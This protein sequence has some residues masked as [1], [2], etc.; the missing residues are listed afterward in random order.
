MSSRMFVSAMVAAALLPV[1]A[2][3]EDKGLFIGL[4]GAGGMATGSS[5]AT[6]G[7]APF[8]GASVVDS[9]DFG[10]TIG[11]GGHVG[12]RFNPALSVFVSYQHVRGDISWDADFP[13]IGVT[14]SF[15][16]DA[17]SNVVMGNIAYDRPVSEATSLTVAAGVGISFNA[18]SAVV[19]TDQGT[20]LFLADLAE[21]TRISPAAQIALGVRHRVASNVQLGLNLSVGYS[22]GF[23]TGDTRTGNL[24]VTPINPYKIDD[25]WRASLGASMRFEF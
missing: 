20:G 1:P 22:G 16:G 14:S 6:N 23:E 7:G 4:D 9:V 21:Q 12:Y 18:L 19:E 3:S 8:A 13:L 11:I 17:I 25:V 10:E 24:G 5:G 2:L 15:E